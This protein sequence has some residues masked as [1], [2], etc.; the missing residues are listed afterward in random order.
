[1]GDELVIWHQY[2]SGPPDDYGR[3]TSIFEDRE[4]FAMVAPGQ[5][6]EPR[7]GT[8]TRTIAEMTIYTDVVPDSRDEFTIRGKR[9]EVEVDTETWRNPLTGSTFGVEIALQKVRG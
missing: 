9:Y 4:I 2:A 6:S 3:P 7:N 5:S 1:M 8:T